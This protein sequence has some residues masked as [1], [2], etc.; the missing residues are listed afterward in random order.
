MTVAA[1]VAKAGP[2]PGNDSASAFSFDFKVFAD[3]DIRVVA[4]TIATGVESDLVLNTDYTVNRNVDQDNNPG[5]EIT[6]KVG[7]VTTAYPSTKKITIV[8]DFTFSQPTDIP[9]GG[10]FFA[11]IVENALD[12]CTSLIKQMKERLDSALTLPVSVDTGVSA[13]LPFPQGS[14]LIGWNVLGTALQNFAGAASVH[15]ST[16]MSS[17]VAATDAPTACNAIGAMP[18]T[19]TV[20][21]QTHAAVGKTTPVD[22]DELPLVDSAASNGLKKLTWANIKATLK[23]YFDTL[24]LNTTKQIQPFTCTQ[25]SNI[26]TGAFAA[27]SLDY[28]S[29]T[30]ATGGP[31]TQANSALTLAIPATSNLGMVLTAQVNRLVWAIAYNAGVPVLCVANIAG[32]LPMDETGFISPTTIGA[33]SNSANVWYSASAVSANSPY[34]IIGFCDVIFTTGTGWSS[35]TLVQGVGGQALTALSS[36][37]YGQTIQSFIAAGVGGSRAVNTTYYNTTGKE[38]FVMLTW[39]GSGST[40]NC[41]GLVVGYVSGTQWGYA[42]FPVPPGGSYSMSSGATPYYWLE[43]R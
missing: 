17:V 2:Y 9:N 18:A 30:A 11:Q 32:G 26:L 7:G 24:Y 34:R 21:A 39:S 1:A 19:N 31:V 20:E 28:R 22:A 10:R 14:A 12:R 8:G 33:S 29:A 6:Y 23:T 35:P 43:R 25:A 38:I 5:G 15:V 37:G 36:A 42:F 16:F 3:T 4:L 40:A 13:E 41:N 27:T